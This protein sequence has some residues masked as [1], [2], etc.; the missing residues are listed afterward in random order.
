[1]KLEGR[2]LLQQVDLSL[3]GPVGLSRG[4]CLPRAFFLNLGC[5]LGGTCGSLRAASPLEEGCLFCVCVYIKSEHL[6]K[7]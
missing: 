1:M 7:T 5:R 3:Q 4:L 2:Q 6:K